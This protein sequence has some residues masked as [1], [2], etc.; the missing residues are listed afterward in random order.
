MKKEMKKILT[1]QFK[2]SLFWCQEKQ[3][4][5]SV[6]IVKLHAK[7]NECILKDI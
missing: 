4:N 1:D 5:Y 7:R 6:V 2:N 3:K